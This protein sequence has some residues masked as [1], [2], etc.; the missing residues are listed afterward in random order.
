M[1]VDEKLRSILE[2]AARS[3]EVAP[4]QLDELGTGGIDLADGFRLSIF[5]PPFVGFVYLAAPICML[6][7]PD[8]KAVYRRALE[9]NYMVTET[10]GGTLA[11]DPEANQLLLCTRLRLQTLTAEILAE[12]ISAVDAV[13]RKLREALLESQGSEEADRTR[14][15]PGYLSV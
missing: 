12:E 4:P 8:D 13:S 1:S 6:G 11:I 7:R 5:A 14:S 15:T 3:L 2:G 10:Q 9:I